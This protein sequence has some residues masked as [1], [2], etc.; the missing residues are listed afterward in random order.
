MQRLKGIAATLLILALLAGT[1]MLL[2]ALGSNPLSGGAW[3]TWQ[4]ITRIFT[5]TDD[6]TMLLG[7]IKIIAWLAWLLLAVLLLIEIGAA[8]RGVKAPP[9]PGLHAPQGM[10]RSLVAT[11]ALL[12]IAAPMA[13][14]VATAQPAHAPAAPAPQHVS[15]TSHHST[16]PTHKHH[17]QPA[18]AET[19]T[20]VKGTRCGTSPKTSWATAPATRRSSRHPRRPSN[21]AGTI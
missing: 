14:G 13:T 7:L 18:K 20:V 19:R 2:L 5:V 16:T 6:G 10:L 21:P 11:A 1:P 3:P 8:L 17:Q 9:L 15:V 12:F 4:Q